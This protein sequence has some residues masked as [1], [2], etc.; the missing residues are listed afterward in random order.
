MT[1]SMQLKLR[2]RNISI[3]LSLHVATT[4]T[5]KE[6]HRGPFDRRTIVY[7]MDSRLEDVIRQP[8]HEVADIYDHGI[9]N[10]RRLRKFSSDSISAGSFRQFVP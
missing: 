8:H 7:S 5:E 9:L 2:P 10:R 6:G 4:S 1:P 3:R